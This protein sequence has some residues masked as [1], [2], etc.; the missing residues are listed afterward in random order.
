M[1]S[2]KTEH[3]K[4]QLIFCVLP[5]TRK[6]LY[7]EIKRVADNVIG[8]VTQCVQSKFMLA[9]KP[10]V[11][12]NITMKVNAKLGGI[13]HIICKDAQAD[14]FKEPII[15]FGADVT[16]PQTGDSIS[17]SIAA[18]V[19][20]INLQASSYTAI[21]RAQVTKKTKPSKKT[22]TVEIIDNLDQ[23]VKELLVRYYK[24]TRCKPVKI[25]FYRD[26]VSEGQFEAVYMYELRAIQKA[27]MELPGKYRPGITLVIVQKRH[28]ARFFCADVKDKSGR[29]GNI[30]AGTTV[31]RG[32]VHPYEFD[33][34]LCSH[35]GI[36]VS[37][38]GTTVHKGDTG[39]AFYAF[40]QHI[41]LSKRELI[42][43]SS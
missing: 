6:A 26:G 17:P 22:E 20:S 13:N 18:V 14:V 9:P 42:S 39:V 16:H 34:Y 29:A 37:N 11:I 2:L 32:V 28:H 3:T 25:L 30:P 10:Q 31:D 23:I 7:G 38:R 36:Q 27:C 41:W 4:L 35:F 40:E 8:V 21:V 33:F 43:R 15:V 24:K 1:C 5:D 19:A 12:A